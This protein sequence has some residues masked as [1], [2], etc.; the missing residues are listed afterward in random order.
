MW[1]PLKKKSD[2]ILECIAKTI[3]NDLRLYSFTQWKIQTQ[4]FSKVISNPNVKYEL[5]TE[6]T[7]FFSGVS[8]RGATPNFLS[9]KIQRKIWYELH[10]IQKQKNEGEVELEVKA[11]TETLKKI[12]PK[13]FKA[14]SQK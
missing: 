7:R 10:R 11:T 8:I 1:W 9:N 12:F 14:K 5:I 4:S 3:L 2:P 13:C 6:S